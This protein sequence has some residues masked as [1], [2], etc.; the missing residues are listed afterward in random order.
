[1]RKFLKLILIF[2]ITLILLIGIPL[3][4]LYFIISDDT[5]KAP[6]ELYN[7]EITLAGEADNLFSR[8]L[9][10][11]EGSF[12]LTLS[13]DDLNRLIFAVLREIN[14][15]YYSGC[16]DDACK[17]V[18]G[19]EIHQEVPIIGGKSINL[20]HGY[21]EIKDQNINFYF[22]INAPYLNTNLNFSFEPKEEAGK[23]TLLLTKLGLGR[24]NLLSGVGKLISDPL[25]SA[26]GVTEE[27]V[28]K[29]IDDLGLPIDFNMED[30]SFSFYKEDLGQMFMKTVGEEKVESKLLNEFINILTS[31]KNQILSFG[32]FEIEDKDYFGFRFNL[33]EIK[34]DSETSSRLAK[35]RDTASTGFDINNFVTN[36]TQTFIIGSLSPD[37]EKSLSFTNTDFNRII[38]DKTAGYADFKYSLV[39]ADNNFEI[40]GIFFDF[41]PDKLNLDFVVNINGIE[42]LIQIIGNI[43]SGSDE[44]E[45]YITLSQEM[46]IGGISASSEFLLE[47]LG[48]FDSLEVVEYDRETATFKI[49]AETFRKFMEVGGPDTPLNVEKVKAVNGGIEVI[50]DYTD[51]SL[52]TMVENARK[53]VEEMLSDNFLDESS[54]DKSDPEQEA[55]IEDLKET[56]GGISTILSDPEAELTNEDT[57]NLIEIINQLSA[58]NQQILLNQI[59]E[60]AESSDLE[61]LY[62]QLFGN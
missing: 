22:T 29:A 6:T 35:L 54:F 45:L 30:F 50:V 16:A 17:Y 51:P 41:R 32:F 43:E 8:F 25:L 27:K 36:K 56:L 19:T 33:N 13:E 18:Q 2:I 58:E 11:R 20:H 23:Y 52:D 12:Y 57:G 49:S 38:Y 59:T 31:S 42:V 60:N 14:P 40:T 44:S 61:S 21:T 5:D 47:M 46:M 10:N 62:N 15:D 53:A 3:T 37:S 24:L 34:T 26:L 39:N 28:N 55:L 48:S 4:S 9:I 1:M 7:N